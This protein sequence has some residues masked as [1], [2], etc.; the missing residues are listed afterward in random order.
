M[1]Y[2][3]TFECLKNLFYLCNRQLKIIKKMTSREVDYRRWWKCMTIPLMDIPQDDLE[4]AAQQ[5]QFNSYTSKNGF[6]QEIERR[7]N[8]F[9]K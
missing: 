3:P 4:W 8:G 7:K 1:N 6:L 9:T 5:D 2:F